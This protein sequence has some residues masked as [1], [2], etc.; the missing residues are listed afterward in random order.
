MDSEFIDYLNPDGG[1][2]G[3]LLRISG[4][5]VFTVSLCRKKNRD[6]DVFGHADVPGPHAAFADVY[7]VGEARVGESI[8]G[9]FGALYGNGGSVFRL[10]DEG[11]F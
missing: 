5:C 2:R 6:D 4:I 1:D 11:V 10:D 3:L 9:T 7:F 8:L